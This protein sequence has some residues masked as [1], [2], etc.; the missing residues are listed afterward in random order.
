M[1]DYF[2]HQPDPER[3]YAL[4]QD[5]PVLATNARPPPL[6]AE[7]DIIEAAQRVLREMF[8]QFTGNLYRLLRSSEPE[9]VHQ[10]RIGWRRFKSSLRLFKPVM[11]SQARPSWQGLQSVLAC[12]GTLR[13]ID[14][15]R[16]NTLPPLAT[17][18][19]AGDAQRA[20][21]WTRMN[22]SLERAAHVQ[23]AALRAALQAPAAGACLLSLAQWLENLSFAKQADRTVLQLTESLSS[24]AKRRTG[25]LHH[26]LHAIC[27]LDGAEN[28]H[29]VRLL[30][31]RLRY[32]VESLSALLPKKI[33]R[34]EREQAQQLQEQIGAQ[35]DLA[36]AVH[37][38]TELAVAPELLAFMRGYAM[39]NS[40]A[41]WAGN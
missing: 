20:S 15:A 35:R 13:N 23:L 37:L 9:A 36:Q 6:H 34:A 14:V 16:L 10:A 7:M 39:G 24:F 31:K 17:L 5:D 21:H 27:Q 3:G 28:A 22:E 4:A 41:P 18:Y 38:L 30:A 11:K 33:R 8:S 12:L 1:T 19:I 2:R 40:D 25:Q 32:N 29:Q 26:Q